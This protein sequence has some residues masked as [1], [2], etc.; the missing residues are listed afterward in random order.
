[1]ETKF[2]DLPPQV[3]NQLRQLQQIQQQ[4]ELLV[5]QKIQVEVRLRD[6]ED[7]LEELNKLEENADVYKGVGNLIIKSEKNKL[8]KELQEEK[9]SVEI[10]KKTIETQEN[11][12]RE[13]INELQS[14][15]QESLKATQ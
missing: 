10:R 8:I 9:E 5:Q 2:E 4:M 1:M 3:Q 13:K 14:K 6:I 7:A 11:R 12:F 15:I